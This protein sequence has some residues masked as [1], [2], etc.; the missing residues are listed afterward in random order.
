MYEEL[1][2]SIGSLKRGAVVAKLFCAD[3]ELGGRSTPIG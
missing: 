3:A 2:R 1:E